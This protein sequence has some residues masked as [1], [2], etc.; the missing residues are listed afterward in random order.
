MC[1][2]LKKSEMKLNSKY[3]FE[4]AAFETYAIMQYFFDIS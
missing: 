4:L 1:F 2:E 3:L